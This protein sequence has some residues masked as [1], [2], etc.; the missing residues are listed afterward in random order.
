MF[1][2]CLCDGFAGNSFGSLLRHIGEIHR[3]DPNLCI[4]CGI[5]GC[6]ETYKRYDSFRSH[7]YRKHR[8]VFY[9]QP[10]IQTQMSSTSLEQQPQG[11]LVNDDYDDDDDDP[12]LT[13]PPPTTNFAFG[14]FIMKIREEY[15]MPQCTVSNILSDITELCRT[16]LD[17]AKTNLLSL[18]GSLENA[19]QVGS[20]ITQ[21]FDDASSAS[22]FEGLETE[23]KQTKY[24]KEFFNYLVRS[25]LF[26]YYYI[27]S[28]I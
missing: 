16:S 26:T 14:R 13:P 10:D 3:H 5:G 15:S 22:P 8:D 1:S 28:L 4:Q 27:A 2:C 23:Y 25:T 21:C 19:D 7:I 17:K 9:L 6:P 20:M 24:F 12:T 18:T 11:S